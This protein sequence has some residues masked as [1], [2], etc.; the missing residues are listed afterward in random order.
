MSQ[1]RQ[2]VSF[3]CNQKSDDESDRKSSAFP[4]PSHSCDT[5]S[6]EPEDT[7]SATNSEQTAHGE[8]DTQEKVLSTTITLSP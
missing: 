1:T 5:I 2:C 3:R 4:S 6:E 7:T 8:I